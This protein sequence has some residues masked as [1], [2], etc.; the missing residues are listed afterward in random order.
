M[1]QTTAALLSEPLHR[2]PHRYQ[3]YRQSRNGLHY[4]HGAIIDSAE[5]AVAAFLHTAAAF[6]G[7]DVRLWDHHEQRHVASADWNVETTRMGFSVRHRSNVFSD[8]ALADLAQKVT[9]REQLEETI[10]ERVRMAV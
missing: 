6:E 9:E 1:I 10:A 4:N 5:Q 8:E 2:T 7:G 3:I